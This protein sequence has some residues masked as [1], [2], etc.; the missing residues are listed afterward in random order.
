MPDVPVNRLKSSCVAGLAPSS[1]SGR[2]RFSRLRRTQQRPLPTRCQQHR[3]HTSE[4]SDVHN[5]DAKELP[6]WRRDSNLLSSGQPQ[7][8]S[9]S[10]GF[11]IQDRER[12]T[13]SQGLSRTSILSATADLECVGSNGGRAGVWKSPSFRASKQLSLFPSA[14]HVNGNGSVRTRA[15]RRSVAVLGSVYIQGRSV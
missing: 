3:P 13:Q 2:L 11:R 4:A 9:S 7:P 10:G 8:S 12:Y 5:G 6:D 15:R 14:P 1:I